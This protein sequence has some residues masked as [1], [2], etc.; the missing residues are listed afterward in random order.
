MSEKENQ[1]VFLNGKAQIIEMLK[2]M[3]GK[4]KEVLLKN[5]RMKNPQ[6]ADELAERSVTLEIMKDLSQPDMTT[7]FENLMPQVLGLALR[8]MTEEVQRKVLSMAPREYA[9]K[10]FEIMVTPLNAS[11]EEKIQKA[12]GRVLSVL[13]SIARKKRR[14]YS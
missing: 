7:L 9:E 2:M 3:N 11:A 13:A 12:Q 14:L 10:A 8:N 4:E 5:I 6:L 1:G